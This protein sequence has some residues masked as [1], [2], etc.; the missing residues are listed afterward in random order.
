MAVSERHYL[1]VDDEILDAATRSDSR[2]DPS[3][4][5]PQSE[6]ATT[7]DVPKRAA[8]SAA[9]GSRTSSQVQETRRNA[10]KTNDAV[11]LARNEE[12][13]CFQGVS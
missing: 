11:I 3:H 12:T 9:I 8:E 2:I 7:S 10:A 5:R 13:P 6:T 4:E 1:Q